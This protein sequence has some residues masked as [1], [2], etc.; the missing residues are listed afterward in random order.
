M[1]RVIVTLTTLA[2]ASASLT[3]EAAAQRACPE[4][5]TSSGACVNPAVGA[6]ARFRG[7]VNTQ[8]KF[9]YSTRLGLPAQDRYLL[10]PFD[11]REVQRGV[12]S[13]NP[14][15]FSCHPNC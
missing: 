6:A 11:Y 7:I 8:Q 4:G 1:K 9:S 5:R 3:F 12:F 2:I 13:T 14:V 15:P 10:Q